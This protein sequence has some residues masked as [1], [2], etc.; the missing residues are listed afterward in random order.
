VVDLSKPEMGVPVVKVVAPR[1]AAPVPL[2]K[3][4]NIVTPGRSAPQL[5]AQA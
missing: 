2:I 4:R 3:G 5:G 1:L